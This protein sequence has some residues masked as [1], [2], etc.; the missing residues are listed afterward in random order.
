[1][2]K[3]VCLDEC[4][5]QTLVFPECLDYITCNF[6]GQTHSTSLLL[7]RCPVDPSRE[8]NQALLKCSVDK[9]NHPIK[10]PDLVSNY[11]IFFTL[12]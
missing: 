4:C 5:R 2:W 3:G 6:C 8:E 10:G 7:F 11:Y 12:F 1:M 9:F